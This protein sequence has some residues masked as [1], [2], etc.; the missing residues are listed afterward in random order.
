VLHETG[1]IG[2][3]DWLVGRMKEQHGFTVRLR[4][5]ARAEPDAQELRFLFFECA[6]ELLLNVVK[7]AGVDAADLMLARPPGGALE[8]VVSDAGTGFDADVVTRRR[9]DEASFGLFS[10]KE[11]LAHLGGEMTIL[12]A[13]E[14]GTRVILRLPLAAGE[15]EPAWVGSATGAQA[16][17]DGL[18]LHPMPDVQ[19]VLIVD[20]HQI[21]RQGLAGLI[22]FE[23]DIEVVGEAAAGEEAVAMAAALRPDVILMDVNLGAGIDGIEATRRVLAAHPRV[24]VIGLSMHG[25]SSVADAMRDAGA[26]AYVTKG[27]P[28]EELL[29]VIRS[30]DAP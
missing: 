6:R 16:R 3:L 27:G 7:H 21:M 20:D 9:V 23:D 10:I 1:L 5:D 26:A 4:T 17:A 28:C 11:R 30:C 2:A 13:P 18:E 22:R 8:L 19:R 25:D 24:R 14:R 29:A 15:R 12:S